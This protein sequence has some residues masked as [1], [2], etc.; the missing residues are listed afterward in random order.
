MKSSIFLMSVTML[1]GLLLA[2]CGSENIVGS[3]S[4]LPAQLELTLQGS[5]TSKTASSVPAK[6]HGT[7]PSGTGTITDTEGTVNRITVGIFKKDDGTTDVISETTALTSE[8]TLTINATEG[9]REIIVVANAP[10]SYFS[11]VTT[12]AAFLAKTIDLNTTTPSDLGLADQLSNDLPMTGQAST[13]QG[14]L[15]TT[16]TLSQNATA[17]A[18]VSLTRLVSRISISKVSYAFSAGGLYPT[19]KFT[20]TEIFLYQAKTTTDCAVGTPTTTALGQGELSVSG[21]SDYRAY[22][23]DTVDDFTNGSNFTNPYFY[24]TFAN[25]NT[26]FPTKLI[27]KGTFDVDGDGVVESA[28]GDG[29]VYYP[30]VIN[31]SQAGTTLTGGSGDATIDRNKTYALTA[32]IKGKGVSSVN[33]DLDPANVSL[34]VSVAPWDLAITQDVTFE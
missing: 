19:A 20:P 18:Y 23:G 7:L 10:A 30:I 17:S 33:A 9:E 31:K 8:N 24:Y 27:I 16:V 6:A 3:E 26:S 4:G 32:T 34:T 5:S 11:G 13:T 2:S 12:K 14:G 1:S 22:L 28:D 21:S 29:T 25:S 15:V